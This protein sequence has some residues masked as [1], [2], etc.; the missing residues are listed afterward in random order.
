M[1]N[2]ISIS[3]V[4]VLYNY[5]VH[6]V[7]KN[8]EYLIEQVDEIVFVDNSEDGLFREIPFFNRKVNSTFISNS[9]NLGIAK[10]QNL[11]A[12][13][14][15]DNG[16][17]YIIFFDQ[18]SFINS[19]FSVSKLVT[20]FQKLLNRGVSV[21]AVSP[22]IINS[23]TK[24]AYINKYKNGNDSSLRQLVK[25]ISSGKMVSKESFTKVGMMR[26]ELFID[27]VDFDW[28]WRANSLGFAIYQD[29]DVTLTHS[30]GKP[31]KSILGFNFNE[32]ADFRYYYIY[33]NWIYLL[34]FKHVPLLAKIK[35]MVG[36][37]YKLPVIYVLKGF[38]KEFLLSSISGMK[39]GLLG[40]MGKR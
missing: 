34:R 1:D 15:L 23:I 16:A 39:D 24:E 11:G 30:I 25:C 40:R 2:K 28:C 36:V 37:F 35:F 38:S 26:D 13:S 29:T 9:T 6:T 14:A 8:F 3:A 7:T 18:D 17:E 21:A 22:L 19:E 27:L 5:D 32:S 33:R 10:A 12:K 31:T 4:V 20:S